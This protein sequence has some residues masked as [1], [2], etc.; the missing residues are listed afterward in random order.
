M[1][2]QLPRFSSAVLAAVLRLSTATRAAARQHRGQPISQ[3]TACWES[4]QVRLSANVGER[5]IQS[6]FECTPAAW[7]R[8]AGIADRLS[9][10]AIRRVAS[11]V[12]HG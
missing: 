3:P 6:T 5:R 12:A 4:G 7:S 9:T 8:L 1:L 10:S 2:P 11:E